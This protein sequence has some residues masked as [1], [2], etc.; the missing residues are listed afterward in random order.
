M[1]FWNVNRLLYS[2][3]AT[4]F[5]SLAYLLRLFY[6]WVLKFNRKLSAFF[7]AAPA[8]SLHFLPWD[9][10]HIKINQT[11]SDWNVGWTAKDATTLIGSISHQ[12][13]F[14]MISI[15]VLTLRSTSAAKQTCHLTELVIQ[16]KNYYCMLL[17]ITVFYLFSIYRAHNG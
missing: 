12:L 13:T 14:I 5:F 6:F 11:A 2:V 17:L 1:C 3:A 7:N 8:T 9:I 15:K 4:V 10:S 16:L